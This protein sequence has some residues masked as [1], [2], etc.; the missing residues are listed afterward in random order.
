MK[1]E[2]RLSV[3]VEQWPPA[4]A[5]SLSATSRTTAAD[6]KLQRLVFMVVAPC[7]RIGRAIYDQRQVGPVSGKTRIRFRITTTRRQRTLPAAALQ[8]NSE[9][10]M[11]FQWPRV[12]QWLA[13]N[14]S[15][16]R[17][18]LQ[19]VLREFCGFFPVTNPLFRT[20]PSATVL[21]MSDVIDVCNERVDRRL[22]VGCCGPQKALKPAP[23]SRSELPDPAADSTGRCN[24]MN[25]A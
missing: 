20:S 21:G 5:V 25:S 13:I 11:A 16:A 22:P 19:Y 24:T 12:L 18:D 7:Q 23:Q 3:S 6:A 14:R 8:W 2:G 4:W 17:V 15:A 1:L 10:V 9:K